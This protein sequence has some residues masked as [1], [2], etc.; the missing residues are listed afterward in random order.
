VSGYSDP[1]LAGDGH[2]LADDAEKIRQAANVGG[3]SQPNPFLSGVAP[4]TGKPGY[5]LPMTSPAVRMRPGRG[6]Y[7]GVKVV[8]GDE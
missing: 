7:G 2:V 5:G 3:V 1:F 4:D 8:V 6:P